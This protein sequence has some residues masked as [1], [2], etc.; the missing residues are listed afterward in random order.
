MIWCS[1][2]HKVLPVLNLLIRY[3]IGTGLGVSVGKFPLKLHL[4]ISRLSRKSSWWHRCRVV[5]DGAEVETESQETRLPGIL[6]VT[7]LYVRHRLSRRRALDNRVL[8]FGGG[9]QSLVFLIKLA[10]CLGSP[11]L[12]ACH[13]GSKP[14]SVGDH[15]WTKQASAAS[16]PESIGCA[17]SKEKR[18][19]RGGV[20]PWG[21]FI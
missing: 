16:L 19:K 10:S 8:V 2:V 15:D 7:S 6:G 14:A 3:V 18:N 9:V 1:E 13:L 20:F 12:F 17:S 5:L 11:R 4:N 21:V